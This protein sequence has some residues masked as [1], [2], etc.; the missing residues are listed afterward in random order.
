MGLKRVFKGA[1]FIPRRRRGG[2]G[3][4]GNCGFLGHPALLASHHTLLR[5]PAPKK[6]GWTA[7]PAARPPAQAG[8]DRAFASAPSNCPGTGLP[9][10]E[11]VAACGTP[12]VR[13]WQRVGPPALPGRILQQRVCGGV[14]SGSLRIT[15]GAG[16][17]VGIPRTG[18]G[19]P[20]PG[21]C[22]HVWG[23]RKGGGDPLG[24]PVP[25]PR[26]GGEGGIPPGTGLRTPQGPTH[27]IPQ[28]RG[29]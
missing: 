18:Q 11:G 17:P 3:R 8:G 21:V 7:A 14:G 29:G 5:A 2:P 13:G 1:S 9:H 6:R 22:P 16:S 19:G 15:G 23:G 28:P 25:S 26:E 10:G 12:T 27:G 24:E 4:P 20:A